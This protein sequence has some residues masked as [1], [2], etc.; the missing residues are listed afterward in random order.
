MTTE[1]TQCITVISRSVK[2]DFAHDA[3]RARANPGTGSQYFFG[4]EPMP[5]GRSIE[6]FDPVYTGRKW[7]PVG[8]QSQCVIS[9]ISAAPYTCWGKTLLDRQ[10]AWYK[11]HMF[12]GVARQKVHFEDGNGSASSKT[13]ATATSGLTPCRNNG[14]DF[15]HAGQICLLRL[16]DRSDPKATGNTLELRP[17]SLESLTQVAQTT[18]FSAV[19]AT[20][21]FQLLLESILAPFLHQLMNA[22]Q[23]YE[24]PVLKAGVTPTSS[25]SAMINYIWGPKTNTI[26]TSIAEF[27]YS[28]YTL[29]VARGDKTAGTS[30]LLA[31]TIAAS[32]E[33]ATGLKMR[34]EKAGSGVDPA[35][36]VKQKEEYDRFIS[37]FVPVA[38]HTVNEFSAWIAGVAAR[39]APSGS[40]LPIVLSPC[41]G[42][43]VS[44]FTG[45]Q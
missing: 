1:L 21:P 11:A 28:G 5:A 13:V 6:Q 8:G 2:N 22:V 17:F 20:Q 16:P 14:P 39:D 45:S 34:M 42:A 18:D 41:I 43:L 37:R 40:L 30:P 32:K 44:G 15:I 7:N 38:G 23:A 26:A 19:I 25:Q 24:P 9:H 29:S 31:N 10:K 12:A 4:S 33:I 27:N 3:Q 36:T 35:I